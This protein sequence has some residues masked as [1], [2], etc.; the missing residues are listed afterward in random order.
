MTLLQESRCP[1][2]GGLV[3]VWA[4]NSDGISVNFE[5]LN[6]RCTSGKGPWD[7]PRPESGSA[8]YS[9][10]TLNVERNYYGVRITLDSMVDGTGTR[11]VLDV[12]ELLVADLIDLLTKEN[13]S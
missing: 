11:T 7:T 3:T 13:A 12:P 10:Y 2:C 6:A 9:E 4:D 1:E 5:C 8:T